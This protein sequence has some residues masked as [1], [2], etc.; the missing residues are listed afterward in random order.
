VNPAWALPFAIGYL[1][2]TVQII[3]LLRYI[4]YFGIVMPVLHFI[5]TIF[6][7]YVLLYSIYKTQI[8]GSITWRG[9]EIDVRKRSVKP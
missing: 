2:Y 5:S 3:L 8:K 9:R 4:G 1:L 6:F 7:L